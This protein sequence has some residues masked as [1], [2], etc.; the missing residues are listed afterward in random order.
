MIINPT[1][2]HPRLRPGLSVIELTAVLAVLI[3]LIAILFVGMRAY[4]NSSDRA[5]CVLNIH[6]V[7]NAVRSYS[8]LNGLAP[9]QALTA[10]DLHA[11]L[12]GPDRFLE[13]APTCPAGGAYSD[14]GNRIPVH[15]ELYLSC[16]LRD[17]KSHVPRQINAW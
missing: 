5:A 7:Q 15:G 11:Q 17:S 4:K 12:V 9:G 8:N 14:L 10:T 6:S 2:C 13:A 3:A 16:S 1:S